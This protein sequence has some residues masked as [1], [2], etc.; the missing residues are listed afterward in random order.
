LISTFFLKKCI[1]AMGVHDE[2]I[3]FIFLFKSIF[4]WMNY[5][6]KMNSMFFFFVC[7][8]KISKM[9][10]LGY[11][12]AWMNVLILFETF[13]LRM[14]VCYLYESTW[15]VHETLDDNGFYDICIDVWSHRSM[16]EWIE[17]HFLLWF[18]FKYMNL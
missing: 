8:N 10:A 16:Y 4:Y 17:S 15:I 6:M 1:S 5:N 18:F 7:L 13:F 9:N 2:F 14:H 11:E 12:D 3:L